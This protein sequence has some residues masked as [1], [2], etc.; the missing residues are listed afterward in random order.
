MPRFEQQADGSTTAPGA[1]PT[2]AGL[3][4]L[5]IGQACGGDE[6]QRRSLRQ[7][8]AVAEFVASVGD[9]ERLLP[10]CHFDCI[11]VEVGSAADP[12]LAWIDNLHRS[13]TAPCICVSA[14]DNAS[15]AEA[16][17][18]AGASAVLPLPLD[19]KSLHRF[20]ATQRKPPAYPQAS[21][22]PRGDVTAPRA[23]RVQLV[24]DGAP[25]RRV[26]QV[27]DRVAP[28][29]ATVLI[30]GH[31]GTGKELVA[32]LV[33]ERSG[34]RGPFVPVNCGAIPPDL[35]ETELFGHAKGAFTGA[36]QQRDGLFVA[37]RGGTLFLDEVSEMR[38]D[39][40]VKLLRALE[41]GR[42]RPVGAD[43][44]IPI[45]VRIIA[46]AQPGLRERVR[47]RRFRE[48]LFYRL[49]VVHI[50]LPCLRERREDI[51]ALVQ[52]FMRRVADEFSMTPVALDET[53]LG[54]L[55]ARDWPGNVRE[56]RNVI[57]RTVLMGGPPED[58]PAAAALSLAA[59]VDTDDGAYPLD[60]TLE[61]VKQAHIMRVL[62]QNQGNRSAT[63]R[64]LGVSRKTLERRLGRGGDDAGDRES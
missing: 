38:S 1:L 22:A 30:E 18:R 34:R 53:A 27:I 14:P 6:R 41:E 39:L 46:S 11:V 48:D 28:T 20:I 21:P 44:E 55:C 10:R 51:P 57:E 15:L 16:S 52:H 61:Q 17:L 47:E 35:M 60:W 49:N 40:Q 24:G 29:P 5:F 12:A 62:A 37:A 9:A 3:S 36:H 23:T 26:R 59:E 8:A 56:L 45:D 4:L 63:A 54:A 2:Q 19:A 64:Q 33:H 13:G 31:T 32:Q 50:L 43:R 42:I 7:H 58:D 25:I